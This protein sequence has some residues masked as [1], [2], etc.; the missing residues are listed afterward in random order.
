MIEKKIVVPEGM[1]AAAYIAACN[2]DPGMIHISTMEIALEA[3]CRWLSE[4][5]IEPTDA[6]L[7]DLWKSYRDHSG[8]IGSNEWVCAEWQR[9]MFLAPEPDPDEPIKDILARSVKGDFDIREAFRRGQKE[10]PR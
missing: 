7:K 1:R 5:P 10:G 2:E 6:Q 3:A 9:R 8:G 4:N